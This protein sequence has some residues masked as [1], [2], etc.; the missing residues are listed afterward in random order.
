M[1]Y[2][3]GRRLCVGQVHLARLDDPVD[4]GTAPGMCLHF[5]KHMDDEH[6]YPDK[7][8]LLGEETMHLKRSFCIVWSGILEWW[9]SPD[10]AM[11][12]YEGEWS[13]S[14]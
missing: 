4:V 14:R 5:V 12:Y 6:P 3:N 10:W 13:A 7:M 2:N 11:L 8:K 9:M 1:H